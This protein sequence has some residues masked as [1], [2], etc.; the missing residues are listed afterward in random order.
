M[1]EFQWLLLLSFPSQINVEKESIQAVQVTMTKATRDEEIETSMEQLQLCDLGS[2]FDIGSI[3]E[4]K[5]DNCDTAAENE[6]IYIIFGKGM[7]LTANALSKG[8]I[9]KTVYMYG[10]LVPVHNHQEGLLFRVRMNFFERKC[11]FERS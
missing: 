9:V 8:R 6:Y 11:I 3:A 5:V 2:T 4:L 7:K 10:I 1:V